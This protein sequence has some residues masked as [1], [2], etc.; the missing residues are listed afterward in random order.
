MTKD[1]ILVTGGGGYIGSHAVLALMEAGYRP[2]V[3]DDLSTGSRAL[4]PLDVPLVVG[5]AGDRNLVTEVLGRFGCSA[6][7]HFAASISVEESVRRPAHYWRNNAG[8]TAALLEACAGAKLGRFIFS[9]TAAVYGNASL[10]PV[11]E[12]TPCKPLNPYGSSKLACEQMISDMEPAC[13]L[14]FVALRYFNV[15]GADPMGR[16]G[17]SGPEASHLIR[18]A[19]E[20]A[21]G[22]RDF[23]A[24]Y[25][26]DYPTPDGTGVRDYIHVSDVASAHVAALRYL[27]SDGQ[28]AIMNLGYGQGFSVREV[29]QAL[30]RVHGKALPV[31]EAP[32]REGDSAAV[33]ADAT[34]IRALLDWQPRHGSLDHILETALAWERKKEEGGNL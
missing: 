16:S 24:I 27:E 15:A 19:C 32:R 25:G 11:N 21:L 13:G 20:V 18:S 7:M 12:E 26:T 22:R 10:E 30:E 9:S 33:V 4:V 34:R 28:S 8:T 1:A 23:L 3:L 2:V 29:V 14:R 5:N 17:Q 31:K 6:V